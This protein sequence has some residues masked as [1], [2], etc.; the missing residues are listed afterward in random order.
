MH[1]FS[2]SGGGDGAARDL[3]ELI[4]RAQEK[5]ESIVATYMAEVQDQQA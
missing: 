4:L 3:I 1:W 5:W 2:R